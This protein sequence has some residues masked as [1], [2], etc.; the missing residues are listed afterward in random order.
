MVRSNTFLSITV[1]AEKAGCSTRH[2]RRII[3]GKGIPV[4]QI[5]RKLF[6][7]DRDFQKW[8]TNLGR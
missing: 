1:A 3:E 4:V 2:F 7:L 6:I 5:R 8:K